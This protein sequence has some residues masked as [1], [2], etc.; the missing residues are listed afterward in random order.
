MSSGL[1]ENANFSKYAILIL[2]S[3]KYAKKGNHSGGPLRT[4]LRKKKL[5]GLAASIAIAKLTLLV[6]SRFAQLIRVLND[7]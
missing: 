3:A 7:V 4:S 5:A 6:Q 2:F 1:G